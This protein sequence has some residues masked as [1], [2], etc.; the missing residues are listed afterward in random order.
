[1]YHFCTISSG[2]AF[3]KV[4]ALAGSLI[5]F[6][7]EITLHAFVT[8]STPENSQPNVK[9]YGLQQLAD[10]DLCNKVIERYR[11]NADKLRWSLKP[12][13][14]HFLLQQKEIDKLIFID[15]DIFF[16]GSFQFLFNL[17][18]EHTVLLTP[19]YYNDDPSK[20]QNWLEANF[21][22]GLFNGGFIG[23]NRLATSSLLWWAGCCIYRCE[24]NAIRGLFYD[25][26]Y[27]TL[28][29]VM[30]ESATIVRHKGCNLA[31]WNLEL[32]PRSLNDG[33][34]LI[35]GEFPVIFIHF[36]EITVRQIVEGR[37]GLLLPYLEQ[38]EE[39]LKRYKPGFSRSEL[40]KPVSFTDKL[41]YMAW[42]A[43]S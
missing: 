27:L 39:A 24:K 30:E 14:M 5:N 3:Y 16:F 11:N 2:E 36:N 15:N 17:L 42:K 40:Y 25:Q 1:M 9:T 26:R 18:T 31:G 19:H 22:R 12:A 20:N 28:L 7:D 29:P 35:D 10:D 34:V 13:F 33:K 8:D 21:N 32:A 38:Y 4:R 43:M 6:G 37:D 23:V 41:K